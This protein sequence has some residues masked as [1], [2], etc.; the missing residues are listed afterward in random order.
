MPTN[1]RPSNANNGLS[2]PRNSK[3]ANPKLVGGVFVD[4]VGGK[5]GLPRRRKG[6][7]TGNE[8][9]EVPLVPIETVRVKRVCGAG[10]ARSG[11]ASL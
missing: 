2:V 11:L 7:E 9:D 3:P 4:G 8:W 10:K 6:A 5:G 1:Q